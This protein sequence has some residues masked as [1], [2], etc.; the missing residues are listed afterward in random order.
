[1]SSS[2]AVNPAKRVRYNLGLVLGVDEFDEE[3]S[4]FL[5]QDRQHHRALHG[6]GTVCGLRLSHDGLKIF[7]GAG[8]AVNPQGKVIRVPRD[9]CADL[10]DWLD[11]PENRAQLEQCYGSP[12]GPASLYVHLCYRECETDNV[13]LP[14]APCRTEE[15]TLAASRVTET[16]ELRLSPHPPRAD[17]EEAVRV[18]GDLLREIEIVDESPPQAPIADVIA[19]VEARVRDLPAHLSPEGWPVDPCTAIGSPLESPLGSPLGSPLE[20]GPLVVS[21]EDAPEV[22]RAA[23]RVWTTEVRPALLAGRNCGAYSPD[24]SCVLL[25]QLRFQIRADG[26]IET[27]TGP[28]WLEIA[29]DER[30]ILLHSR[31]LQE[32]LPGGVSETTIITGGGST[33]PPG[34]PGPAGPAGPPGTPGSVGPPGTPGPAGPPGPTGPAGPAGRSPIV[35]AGRFDTNGS[36]APPF[37]FSVGGLVVTR[38]SPPIYYLVRFD[39]FA[40]GGRFVLKGTVVDFADE[41]LHTVEEVFFFSEELLAELQFDGVDPNVPLDQQGI[42]IRVAGYRGGVLEPVNLGFSLEISQFG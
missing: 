33:G 20:T 24:E 36:S 29:Q 8:V 31:L 34:P 13:P 30:P 28:E 9:Q 35:A 17:E 37:G 18:F 39:A 26:T 23:F 11:V 1:M 12:P 10:G 3:Q 6:Y 41:L 27:E 42:G 32:W 14:G 21:R 22:L 5:E 7:V 15:D 19:E 38:G 4:Y 25:G 2:L 16:F 40:P